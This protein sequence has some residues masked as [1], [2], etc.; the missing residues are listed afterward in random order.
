ML[1]TFLDPIVLLAYRV[2]HLSL[3]MLPPL[4]DYDRT[5][6][7]VK[8]SFKASLPLLLAQ[9][10]CLHA[11]LALGY[12]HWQSQETHILGI[13]DCFPSVPCVLSPSRRLY[14]I[15]VVNTSNKQ[16]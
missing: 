16:S 3:D 12:F 15:K 10:F 8:R 14:F 13:H 9:V 1:Y 11:L 2:P 6:N 7:L 4:A 5:R